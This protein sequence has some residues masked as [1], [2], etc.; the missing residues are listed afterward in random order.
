MILSDTRL[1][2]VMAGG[3]TY[4][5]PGPKAENA[6][7]L[8]APGVMVDYIG[9]FDRED[10]RYTLEAIN[11]SLGLGLDVDVVNNILDKALAGVESQGTVY[12]SSEVK[13][14]SENLRRF[15]ADKL[16][17]EGASAP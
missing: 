11:R 5:V 15:L 13:T 1:R 8:T 14:V 7:A 17:P 3:E 10:V 4:S 9:Q 16:P 6:S 12:R 2:F